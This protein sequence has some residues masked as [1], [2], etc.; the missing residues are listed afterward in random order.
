[1]TATFPG[2]IASLT[3]VVDNVT[4]VLAVHQ[5]EK[6]DEIE[7]V[8]TFLSLASLSAN[9]VNEE[10]LAAAKTLVDGDS[11]FQALD[12]DGSDRVITLPALDADNHVFVIIHSGAANVLTVKNPAAATLATVAAGQGRTFYSTGTAWYVDAGVIDTSLATETIEIVVLDND[13]DLAVEDGV[14]HFYF[15][16]PER[17]NGWNLNAAHAATPGT[18]STSGTPTIQVHNVT[19]GVDILSTRITIDANEFSSYTAA[20]ASVVDT[21]HDDLATGDRLRFDCDVAGTGT[22]GLSMIL[23]AAKP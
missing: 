9:F 5:N 20:A 3:R 18:A 15:V 12:P 14:S 23:T 19:D 7:A 22:K 17:W 21:D 11:P 13:T 10:T 4:D 2:G 16:V 8:E 1:M 6:A